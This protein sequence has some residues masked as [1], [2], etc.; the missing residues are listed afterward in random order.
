MT[1]TIVNN[2]KNLYSLTPKDCKGFSEEQ[3]LE[4]EKRLAVKFPLV[5]R[6]YYLQLGATESVNQSFNSLATPEQLYFDGDFFCFCE[7]NQGVVMW[8][9]RKEDLANPNPPVWGNYGTE[10]NPDWIQETDTL[11][12]FWL[13]IAIYNGTLGGLPYNANAMGGWDMEGFEVPEQVISY[14][15]K[16]YTELTSLSRKGQ[17]TFTDANFQIV[18]TLAIHRDTNR[19]TAIFIGSAQQE[20]FD[21]LLDAM[22]NFGL[23]WNYTSYDD[24]GDD[25]FQ[26]VSEAELNE[27]KAKGLWILS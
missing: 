24:N 1:E 26:V 23:E 10:T 4:A 25:E 5:F 7:E 14:I 18:I 9:I 27:L 13:Y 8:A 21:T 17:R 15:E 2:I 22:E 16:Q 20:L 19:A 3:L 11:S 6:E 12:D